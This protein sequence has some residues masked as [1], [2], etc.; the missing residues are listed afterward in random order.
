MRALPVLLM[1]T[2]LLALTVGLSFAETIYVG[3]R[4]VIGIREI[5]EDSAP[6]IGTLK[7]DDAVERLEDAD[8]FYKVRLEDGT[9]GYVKKQY[10]TE[11]R[12]KA[13]VIA[14]LEKQLASQKKVVADLKASMSG[15]QSELQGKQAELQG[16][17]TELKQQLADRDKQLV[18][19]GR[20]L[21]ATRKELEKAQKDYQALTQSAADVV[22]VVKAR[23]A[24]QKE[25]DRLT[26]ELNTMRE[27]SVYLLTVFYI[28]WFLAGAGVMLVGWMIGR[29]ARQKRRY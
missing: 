22:S 23:E 3:D 16:S 24:L 28:K 10:M 20:A 5:P 25:N 15:S 26:D 27:D 1:A 13:L 12:P 7:T 8:S 6:S 9:E 2:V 17:L 19:S 11:S 21:D 14:D 29:S 18:E 4:L